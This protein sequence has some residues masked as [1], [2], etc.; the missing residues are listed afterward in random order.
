MSAARQSAFTLLEVVIVLALVAVV[1]GAA[2]L[3]LGT[4][5]A[6]WQLRE[7]ADRLQAVLELASDY[8][9]IHHVPLRLRSED[10]GYEMDVW[11]PEG[12][13]Q[14]ASVL[15]WPMPVRPP[16]LLVQGDAPVV[17]DSEGDI[18]PFIWRITMPEAGPAY[19]LEHDQ[20]ARF[21]IRQDVEQP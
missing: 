3:S 4:R 9:L 19:A 6:Q 14:P 12:E 1:A 11:G 21:H 8:S 7:H 17:I 5:H 2:S 15:T 16:G 20:N 10:S 13:W 18:A